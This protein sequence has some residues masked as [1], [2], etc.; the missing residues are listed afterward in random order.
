MKIKC[1]IT[2]LEARIHIFWSC[3]GL[4][5]AREKEIGTDSYIS[6]T[7]WD[8]LLDGAAMDGHVGEMDYGTNP[9]EADTDGDNWNDGDEVNTYKTN[10]ILSDT[11]SDGVMDSEDMNPLVDLKVTVSINEIL[12]IDDIDGP[13]GGEADFYVRVN[14]DEE[15]FPENT[16]PDAEEDPVN[17]DAA[18]TEENGYYWTNADGSVWVNDDHKT[19]DEI[20]NRFIFTMNVPDDADTAYIQIALFDDNSAQA[21]NDNKDRWCDISPE[22]TTQG[23]GYMP[24]SSYYPDGRSLVLQYDLKTGQ[25]AGDD[26]LGDGNGYGHASGLEDGSKETDEDDCEIWFGITMNDNDGDGLA[27]WEEVNVFHT[28]PML[29][30]SDTD[31]DTLPDWYERKYCT[32][33]S[34]SITWMNP[35]DDEDNDNLD[36]VGEFEYGT[37][38]NFFEVNLVVS[39]E[40]NADEEYIDDFVNG[41]KKASDYLYDVTD[42][43]LY[44][45]VLRFYDNK[46]NW[47]DADIQVFGNDEWPRSNVGGIDHGDEHIYLPH[48]WDGNTMP[49]GYSWTNTSAY[50]TIIHEFG[51]YALYFYDEYI[52]PDGTEID[53][54][55]LMHTLMAYQYDSSEMSTPSDYENTNYDTNTAQFGINGESCWETFFRHYSDRIYFDIDG[56]SVRD[57][58]TDDNNNGIIDIFESYV[59]IS[60]PVLSTEGAYTIVE[61]NNG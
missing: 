32:Q 41:M 21:P 11:D 2:G 51:H 24:P 1:F 39:F 30:D 49:W 40:W 8:G 56:D 7:D 60:G 50:R 52:H 18:Q 26:F 15:W 5:D 54:S 47:D 48:N 3:D 37:D 38:P 16:A 23:S 10:P 46:V 29:K 34:P 4:N 58:I 53:R 6:D 55:K 57:Q 44:F 17:A 36:N 14:I 31:G 28:D 9:L 35:N 27:Y 20:G 13:D 45:R 33:T 25:W 19:S 61:V 59:P 12:A 42:G 22:S 43:Y